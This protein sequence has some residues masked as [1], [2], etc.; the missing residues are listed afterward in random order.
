M[1]RTAA[2][3]RGHYDDAKIDEAA[4]ERLRIE[5]LRPGQREAIRSVLED[6][7]TL[8]VFPSGYGKSAIYEIA[9]ALI[10]GPTVVVSPLISLQR[11]QARAIDD[12]KVGDAEVVNSTLSEGRREHALD[13]FEDGDLE[14]AF[15]APEQLAR[16]ETMEQLER[17]QPSLFVVDEAHCISA[18]GHDFRPDYERLGDVIERLGHPTVVALTATAAPPVRTDIVERLGM[19]S[20]AIHIQGFDRP[21]ISLAVERYEDERDKVSALVERVRGNRGKAGIVYTSTRRAAEELTHALAEAE[22]RVRTYHAGMTAKEREAA[23]L[24]FA[25]EPIVMVATNAFGMGIDKPDVRFVFH[26]DPPESLDAYYQEVGRSGRDG[27]PAEAMLFYRPEDLGIRRYFAASSGPSPEDLAGVLAAIPEHGRIEEDALREVLDL[28]RKRLT[29]ALNRLRD[30]DAVS[31]EGASIRRGKVGPR[32]VEERARTDEDHHRQIEESR[33]EMVR[34]YAELAQ[35]RRA[36]LLEYFGEPFEGPC[37]NCDHCLSGEV[38]TDTAG[39]DSSDGTYES[40]GRV[41]HNQ[42]GLGQVMSLES[43][44]A[45]ILFEDVGYKT[46]DLAVADAGDLLE[47]VSEND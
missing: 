18:W 32:E 5:A 35:C 2:R 25:E 30:L 45:L 9:G 29:A 7:D 47:P 3:T 38:P 1:A 27:K 20:P 33:V 39:E 8:V 24:A 34:H 6:H 12:L 28:S 43:G 40:G 17:A 19:R 44:R 13:R 11:D 46:I 15:L 22:L 10:P 23:H 26:A 41:R 42:F 37:G 14:F 36:F 31:I 4:R 21:N 16:E